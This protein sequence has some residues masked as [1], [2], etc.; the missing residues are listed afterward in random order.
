M[1]NKKQQFPLWVKAVIIIS[2]LPIALLPIIIDWCSGV[3]IEGIK[4]FLVI[5]PFYVVASANMAWMSYRSRP[6]ITAILIVLMVLTHIAMWVL[7]EV[8]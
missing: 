6:E 3:A 8:Y 2:S 4:I 1:K 5:Y 7:P